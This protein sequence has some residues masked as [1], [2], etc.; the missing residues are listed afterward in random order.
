MVAAQMPRRRPEAAADSVAKF[1]I[2]LV[3]RPRTNIW[4]L[5]KG[6][7]RRGE[8]PTD[9]ALREVREETGLIT[10]V[11]GQVGSI[12]YTFAR[13]GTRYRKEVLHYLLEAVGGDL[14][15]HDAEYDEARWFPAREALA[16]LTFHN[17]A[18]LLQKALDMLAASL[19]A[20]NASSD[21][22]T[23][24]DVTPDRPGAAP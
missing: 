10:R 18:E 6:T 19:S 22:A 14:A 12:Y 9:T 20:P 15:L 4:V 7:P 8:D 24:P 23:P 17:E 21:A 3:G 2:A 11:Q 1:E 5:P 16:R 13:G